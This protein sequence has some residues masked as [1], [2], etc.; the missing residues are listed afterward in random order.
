MNRIEL[1]SAI[2]PIDPRVPVRFRTTSPVGT[3][4]ETGLWIDRLKFLAGNAPLQSIRTS[5]AHDDGRLI[6]TLLWMGVWRRPSW[7]GR[8]KAKHMPAK[9]SRLSHRYRPSM[10]R[11]AAETPFQRRQNC[12]MI[13]HSWIRF[14]LIARCRTILEKETE[15]KQFHSD[16]STAFSGPNVGFA[17]SKPG[18]IQDTR[19]KSRGISGTQHPDDVSSRGSPSPNTG[20]RSRV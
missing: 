12:T 9:K 11:Q 16:I 14:L 20:I 8:I 1:F 4:V 19:G 5:S 6:R 18:S 10:G 15:R 13:R 2:A 3:P 7:S 17:P